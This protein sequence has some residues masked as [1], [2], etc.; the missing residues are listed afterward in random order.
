MKKLIFSFV[1]LFAFMASVNAQP[2]VVPSVKPSVV[3]NEVYQQVL[4][5]NVDRF[6]NVDR[7]QI[8]DSVM[9]PSLT[10][11]GTEFLIADAPVNGV[12]DCLYRMTGKYINGQLKTQPVIEKA[13]EK[14]V[15]LSTNLPKFVDYDFW[16][17]FVFISLCLLVIVAY[18]LNRFRPWNNR[19][20][21]NRNPVVSGGLSNNPAEAAAQIAALIP[22]SRVVK[23]ERGR[24]IGATKA[25][26]NMNF[27][28]GIK[29]VKLISGEEYYRITQDN[30]I[31]RYARKACGNLT[32]GSISNL[33]E[34]WTFV[35]CTEENSAWT[36]PKVEEK[37]PEAEVKPE[38]EEESPLEVVVHLVDSTDLSG[39]EVATILEA[40][41]KM[42]NVPSSITYGDLVVKFYKEN[43]K[44]E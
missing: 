4:Q 37:Q 22:G 36:A 26:V 39:T 34:G 5:L 41:G 24:L 43:E 12:H 17:W 3:F 27:S 29:K 13:Q 21:I 30:G 10:S 31:I 18:L 11:I 20:N 19:R 15:L 16:A 38:V 23:S 44:G 2:M 33:P 42:K 28:D 6:A 25:K 9:F 1:I 40:A 8:G 35:S 32:D 7:I 14:P